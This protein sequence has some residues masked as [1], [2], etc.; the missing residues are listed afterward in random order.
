LASLE[1]SIWYW[2]ELTLISPSSVSIA[3]SN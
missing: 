1:N 3:R 2:H